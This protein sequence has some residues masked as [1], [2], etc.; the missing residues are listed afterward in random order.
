MGNTRTL[1]Y[2]KERKTSV[3]IDL[4]GCDLGGDVS[5][6]KLFIRNNSSK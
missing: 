6:Q 1:L 2:N 3:H 4:R 5:S